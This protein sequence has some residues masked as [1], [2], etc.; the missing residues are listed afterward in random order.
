MTIE[1]VRPNADQFDAL[2]S[3]VESLAEKEVIADLSQSPG[4][5]YLLAGTRQAGFLG[6]VQAADFIDG[7]TAA[8]EVGIA[9]GTPINSDTPWIK[10]MWK[11]RVCFTP[12]KPIRHSVTWVDIYNAG[13]VYASGDEGLV[14]PKGR[15]GTTLS[16]DAT[17]NSINSSIGG[18][19]GDETSNTDYADAIGQVGDTLVLKDWGNG[20]NNGS[21]TI[22]SIT[23]SKIVLSGGAL[24]TESANKLGRFYNDLNDVPQ[25]KTVV[26]G[27]LT[28]RVRLMTG[29][30]SDPLDSY[31]DGDR[32]LIGPECEWNS[33]VLP[34]HERAKT[35]SW[36]YP[37]YAGTVEDWNI[38]LTDLDMILHYT[39][40]SGSYRWCQE[41]SDLTPWRRVYRG[42]YGA[43]YGDVSSSFYVDSSRTWPPVFE[44]LG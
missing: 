24:V 9:S 2:I 11:G 43:S 42:Y 8:L 41:T 30:A 3:A 17:D 26:I 16:I 6:F 5:K 35:G 40:G 23:D 4:S 21:F 13:A 27:G 15:I 14:P 33:I 32:G 34:L 12:L 29:G 7:P 1:R 38:G 10:Y 44:L 19:L 18:F 37:Q 20:A 25:N 28:Y 31:G 39:L 36:N 22:D